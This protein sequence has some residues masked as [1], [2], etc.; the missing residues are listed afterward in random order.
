MKR[1]A[2]LL[3][4]LSVAA[5]TAPQEPRSIRLR[6]PVDARNI[7]SSTAGLGSADLIACLGAWG[8]GLHDARKQSIAALS[9]ASGDAL[10]YDAEAGLQGNR[11]SLRA[12]HGWWHEK[13]YF[14]WGM[15]LTVNHDIGAECAGQPTSKVPLSEMA[16]ARFL[17]PILCELAGDVECWPLCP[18]CRFF[19]SPR[20]RHSLH[21]M[22]RMVDPVGYERAMTWWKQ[23]VGK[24][25]WAAEKRDLRLSD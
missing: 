17:S 11:E 12:W 6:I 21:Q 24:I 5:C 18:E 13:R 3:L 15:G 8:E 23:T 25:T 1:I 2:C 16:E 22:A 19:G 9:R 4:L 10:D 14:V 7:V 20:A